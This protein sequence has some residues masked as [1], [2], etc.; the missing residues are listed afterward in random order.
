MKTKVV[1][2]TRNG[3][4]HVMSIDT[5]AR[6]LC[7]LEAIEVAKRG[8]ERYGIQADLKQKA[9]SEYIN[10]RFPAMKHDIR[11]EEHL[12]VEL[13]DLHHELRTLVV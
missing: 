13:M 7:L 8:E 10:E 12:D 4:E 9:F 5:Y 1:I 11:V 2:K 6:W 3:T